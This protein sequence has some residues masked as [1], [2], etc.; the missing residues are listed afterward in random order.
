MSSDSRKDITGVTTSLEQILV[1]PQRTALA[2][3]VRILFD[4]HE[5]QWELE[6]RCRDR[7][8]SFR[9]VGLLKH[10]IDRS[11]AE[12]IATISS[13]D[14]LD[15]PRGPFACG[16]PERVFWPVTVGQALDQLVIAVIRSE[17][18]Y[19]ALPGLDKLRA[20]QIAGLND[21]FSLLRAGRLVLPPS[22]S[23]KHY[24]NSDVA[25]TETR[26]DDEGD[27]T[28]AVHRRDGRR[29]RTPTSSRR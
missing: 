13:I 12:R 18:I 17:K 26:R 16:S 25:S 9:E 11:N 7:A 23:V 4:I 21:M 2:H 10:D 20:H 3:E 1:G 15:W 5:H 27:A 6:D 22:S 24:R 29:R 14:S 19:S 28:P 8:L